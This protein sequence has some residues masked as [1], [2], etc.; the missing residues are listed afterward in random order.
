[1]KCRRICRELLWLARFGEFGP[2]SQPHLDHLAAC[3]GCRDEVGFDRALVEQLRAAL[4]RRIENANPS[5]TAWERILARAQAPEPAPSVRIWEW[6]TAILAR[7]RMAT[8]MAGTGLALLLALN[9]QIV[10]GALPTSD[11]SASEF[12]R[13]SLQ[14]VPRIPRHRSALS[15]LAE[16]AAEWNAQSSGARRPDPEVALTV[17]GRPPLAARTDDVVDQPA[18]AAST[19]LRLVFRPMQTPEPAQRSV[20]TAAS[21]KPSGS[22]LVPN[23]PGEPS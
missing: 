11:A 2:S 10:P 9:M 8:A 6:S 13:S 18:E 7:L 16:L 22:Q 15:S 5:P 14:Q 4:A 21:P 23:E 20:A 12:E 3:R 1:M 17:V 19:E